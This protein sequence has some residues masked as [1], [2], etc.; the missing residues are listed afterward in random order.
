VDYRDYFRSPSVVRK[1]ELSEYGPQSH[2]S[3][4]WEVEKAQLDQ[5]V[6]GLGSLGHPIN[7]LD[8][9]TGTGRVLEHLAPRVGSAVGIDVSEQMVDIARTKVECPIIC[10]DVTRESGL[11]DGFAPF[12]LITGFRFLLNAGPELRDSALRS[13][14]ELLRD[15][16]SLLVVNNHSN[17]VSHKA[18]LWPVH[19]LRQGGNVT[20]GN[21]LTHRELVRA[22]HAAGLEVV[23]R[24]GAGVVPARIYAV[25]KNPGAALA[26][27][28]RAAAAGVTRFGANQMYVLRRAS[29]S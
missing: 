3:M 8:F 23:A 28:H 10:G 1:Y 20:S 5:I 29:R 4:I 22:F 26:V 11:L 12:D 18:L 16:E 15:D 17:L 7:Y 19:R 21:Y 9:A 13:L 27:E 24:H 2:S 6:S 14:R 25:A